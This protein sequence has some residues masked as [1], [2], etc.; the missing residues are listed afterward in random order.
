[1][2]RQRGDGG[3]LLEAPARLRMGLLGLGGVLALG[4]LWMLLSALLAPE[5]VALP[6]DRDGAAAA[7]AHRGRVIAAARL[8]VVRGDL[9]AQAAFS[10]AELLLLDRAHSHEAASAAEVQAARS[11]AET[12]L[13]LAPVNGSAWFLL[14]ALPPASA[15]PAD[16]N[17]LVALQMSYLTAPNDA[18]LA[19]PASSARWLPWSRS[20]RIC[21]NS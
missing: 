1:M 20:T 19:R 4:G 3:P 14:A 2:P 10:D 12:A 16:A 15:K 17:G 5:T 8:G 6:L 7:A 11:N 21:R 13:A 9:Y 18:A